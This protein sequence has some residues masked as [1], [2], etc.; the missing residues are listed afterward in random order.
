[1]R[2]S[3]TYG[4]VRGALSNER[5]YRVQCYL[6]RCMNRVLALKSGLLR[7]IKSSGIERSTDDLPASSAPPPLSSRAEEFHLRALPEP[8]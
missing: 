8:T 5:P 4:S 7:C 3:R 1:M 6:L 2:E